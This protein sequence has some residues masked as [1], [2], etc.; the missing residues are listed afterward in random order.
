MD[1][2]LIYAETLEQ[3]NE[4]TAKVVDRLRNAGLRLNPEK[5][6]F[7]KKS[8]PYLGRVVSEGPASGQRENRSD[9]EVEGA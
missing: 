8:V 6:L 1:D 9:S 4:I 5:C 7:A 3:L 2:M